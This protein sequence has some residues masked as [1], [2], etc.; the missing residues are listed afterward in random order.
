[1]DIT[2]EMA[3]EEEWKNCGMEFSCQHSKGAFND[4]GEEEVI[5]RIE[6]EGWSKAR[7]RIKMRSSAGSIACYEDG[8]R[9]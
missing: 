4:E 6:D 7:N 8:D 3:E 5:E 1:M 2:E 9:E